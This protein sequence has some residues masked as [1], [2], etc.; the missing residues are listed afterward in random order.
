MFAWFM[1][2]GYFMLI[3][4]FQAPTHFLVA[5]LEDYKMDPHSATPLVCFSLFDDYAKAKDISLVRCDVL[6]R[7][8]SD[9]E[10]KK[11]VRSLLENY[12]KDENFGLVE[13][14][15]KKPNTFDVDDFLSRMNDRWKHDTE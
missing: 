5:Y 11:A 12:G 9:G 4:Q 7:N 14:F 10:C 2:S 1:L 3:S 13:M 8:I 15:N 6:N